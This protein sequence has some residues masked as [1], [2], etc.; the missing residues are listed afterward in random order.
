[1]A[2]T[3]T[4]PPEPVRPEIAWDGKAWRASLPMGDGQVFEA[5]WEPGFT[6]VVRIREKNSGEWSV[7]FETPV[8]HCSFFDLKPDTEYEVKVCV[9]DAKG[10]REISRLATRTDPNRENG[11]ILPFPPPQT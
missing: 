2:R 4:T 3:I 9:R 5:T 10:E 1:M 6:Y 7:G 8:P 11:D